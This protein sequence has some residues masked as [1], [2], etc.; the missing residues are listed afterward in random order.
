[1]GISTHTVRTHLRA[2]FAKLRVRGI[3]GTLRLT[4]LLLH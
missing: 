1:M 4:A 3:A 2:I